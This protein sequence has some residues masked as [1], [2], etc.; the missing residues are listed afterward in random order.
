MD[1]R[2]D[3][4]AKQ[5]QALIL[6]KLLNIPRIRIAET[7]DHHPREGQ[8]KRIRSAI[9]QPGKRLVINLTQQG[10]LQCNR[11][12][13]PRPVIDDRQFSKEIVLLN[14]GQSFLQPLAPS[15]GDLHAAPVRQASTS[16][17]WCP[18]QISDPPVDNSTSWI[19]TER[20]ISGVSP[21]K[22]RLERNA[23]FMT[24]NLNVDNSILQ[25]R[26]FLLRSVLPVPSIRSETT[27]G[28]TCSLNASASIA[29]NCAGHFETLN[30]PLQ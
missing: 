27:N 18:H 2:A 16:I 14:C 21:S 15:F 7:L 24:G 29:S 25:H 10:C 23:S 26:T 12:G 13:R 5:R 20:S 11:S 9:H 6:Q 3:H 1:D 4:R 28:S 8:R 22:S 19:S 30:T 17:L